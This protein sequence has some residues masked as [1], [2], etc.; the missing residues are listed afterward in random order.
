[1]TPSKPGD[2]KPKPRTTG[3]RTGTRSKPK[4]GSASK[5]KPKGPPRVQLPPSLTV[6]QLSELLNASAIEIIKQLMRNGIMANVNQTIAYDIAAAISKGFGYEVSKI[7]AAS[8]SAEMK[9]HLAPHAKKGE[10]LEARP[11]IV[12]VMGHVDHG[13]TTLLDVIRKTNVAGAEAGSITQHIGAYQAQIDGRK[14]TFLDTPGHEAF[15]SMRARGAQVTDIAVLVVAADDGVMPQTLE[16]V[17]HARAAKVPIVIALNKIDKPTANPDLVKKQL[18]DHDLVIEEWGGDVI[19][20]PIAAKKGE[21]IAEL[22][23]NILVVS[24]VLE[25]KANPSRRAIGT[26]IE[27]AM[28]KTK[29]PLATVLVQ[30][31][32]LHRG[33]T[34]V[35]GDAQGRIKAMFNESGERVEEVPPATPA[36]LM[37]LGTVPVAGDILTA[38]KDDQEARSLI[39]KAGAVKGADATGGIGAIG[40]DSLSAGIADGHVKDLNILLKT[41]VQGSIEPIKNSL[42]GL[43]TEKVRVQVIHN[44]TGS[45]T[46]GDVLLA[47]ASKAILVGFNTRPTLGAQR[48][49]ELQGVDI[50]IHKIIYELTDEIGK[51]LRG[52]LE[53]TYVDVVEGRLEVRQLFKAG[54]KEKIAGAM[55]IEGKASRSALARI[56]RNGKVVQE[57]SVSSLRRFKDDVRE[58]ATGLEC[59]IGVE[60]FMAFEVGDV[61]EL[62]RKEKSGDSSH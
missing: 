60:D 36:K 54:K 2:T 7:P 4:D 49:A 30:D 9:K 5:A 41:D 22:L 12:T 11:P 24:E 59:G 28:D 39:Q 50:R 20:V 45:I 51:A 19:Y 33:D 34:V 25:L 8:R 43:T 14:I 40:L 32:T 27:A 16:A 48:L 26:I 10:V 53:P 1:M 52:M 42:E 57:S 29:G 23:E 21:G 56:L 6:A 15:T 38:V 61:I 47:R 13:K 18:F 55:V 46:E 44:D 37:G 58:V 31:G 17:A 3:A 35:V 62:Y